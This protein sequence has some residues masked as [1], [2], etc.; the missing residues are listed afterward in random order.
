V[1]EVNMA[2]PTSDEPWK[3][4]N[5][6]SPRNMRKCTFCT[7]EA[8]GQGQASRI[9]LQIGVPPAPDASHPRPN[10]RPTPLLPSPHS[11]TSHPPSP[12]TTVRHPAR[13]RAL[14]GSARP[15]RAAG[16]RPRGAAH[17]VPLPPCAQSPRPSPGGRATRASAGGWRGRPRASPSGCASP[18][19]VPLPW[20]SRGCLRRAGSSQSG[21]A[22]PRGGSTRA[23]RR[24]ALRR[25]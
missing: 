15:P 21:R 5:T 9:G 8:R 22:R 25:P 2:G 10:T 11:P 4:P 20:S 6:L 14:R 1:R 16:R 19:R 13:G 24:R 3:L 7:R 12:L 18:G 17:G 23:R